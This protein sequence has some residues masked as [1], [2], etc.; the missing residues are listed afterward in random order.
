VIFS[1]Y[2]QLSPEVFPSLWETSGDFFVFYTIFWVLKGIIPLKTGVLR[3]SFPQSGENF[4]R[5]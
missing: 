2:N 4:C 3:E 5:K 1:P